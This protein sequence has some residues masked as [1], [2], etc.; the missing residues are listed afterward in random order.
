MTLQAWVNQVHATL[1]IWKFWHVKILS[2]VISATKTNLFFLFFFFTLKLQ[3]KQVTEFF[4]GLHLLRR[5][6][7][8]A[9]GQTEG[10][11]AHEWITHVCWNIRH[12]WVCLFSLLTGLPNRP[13]GTRQFP[14]WIAA[15]WL[16]KILTKTCNSE[17]WG[18]K[19]FGTF[20][21]NPFCPVKMRTT[22]R[23]ASTY[24]C[25]LLY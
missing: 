22:K 2:A 6:F 11:S 21:A 3:F 18:S 15:L 14:V 19:S 7:C 23:T 9:R 5:S 10:L 17:E 13:E 12:L 20:K 24:L 16:R 8:W 4:G 1:P 25:F